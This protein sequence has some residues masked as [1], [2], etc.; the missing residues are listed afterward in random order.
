MNSVVDL[1]L[2]RAEPYAAASAGPSAQAA[3]R[4]AIVRRLVAAMMLG[5]MQGRHDDAETVFAALEQLLGDARELRISLAFASAIGG[6][7][8]PA[9]TLLAEGVDDWLKPELA[10]VSIALTLKAGGDPE[11]LSI[12]QRTLAVSVD[13]STR[14]YAQQVLDTAGSS[15]LA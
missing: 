7:L 15:E 8:G 3:L 13:V 2:T 11:W 6:D 5:Q 10:M 9:R 12:I 1:D 4:I 14:S